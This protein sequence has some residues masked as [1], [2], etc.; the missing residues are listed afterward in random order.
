ML[1]FFDGKS[2]SPLDFSIHTEK[3]LPKK[4]YKKQFKKEC[5]KNSND[6][7]RREDSKKDKITGALILIK[8]AEKMDFY[9]I[10]ARGQLVYKS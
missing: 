8:R 9:P 10:C 4:K 7:K 5:I 3:S 1:G 2:I 6:F